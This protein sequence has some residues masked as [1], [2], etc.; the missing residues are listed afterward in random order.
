MPA[1]AHASQVRLWRA[2]GAGVRVRQGVRGAAG[3]RLVPPAPPPGSPP[4][5]APEKNFPEFPN[6][7]LD[8]GA[9]GA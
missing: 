7:P 2:Q 1:A 9:G 3:G 5:A 6:F 8:P 4:H